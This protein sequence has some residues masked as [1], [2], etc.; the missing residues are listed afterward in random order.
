LHIISTAGRTEL[1][2]PSSL[3]REPN[4]A[5]TLDTPIHGC[6]DEWPKVFVL[7]SALAGYFVETR[8]VRAISHGLI[9]EVAF[10][11]LVTNWTVE[12]VV[13]KEEFHDAFS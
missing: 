6:L 8:P 12:R 2:D 7:D 1:F 11:T 5:R 9:L 4:A 3:I 10:T 13:G